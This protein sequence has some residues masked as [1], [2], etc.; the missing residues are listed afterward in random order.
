MA[1][2]VHNN[3][4]VMRSI[5]PVAIGTTGT[6][7]TGK[8]VD[9]S[10]YQGVEFIIGYGTITSTTAAFTLVVKEGDAT[11][12]MTSIADSDLLGT[13][14]AAVPA[15]G[16]RVSGSNK[17]VTKRLGY[18]GQK[19]YVQVSKLSSLGTAGPPVHADVLLTNPVSAPVAT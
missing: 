18:I 17:N 11:G 2:D 7:Q 15:A 10:G 12:S 1:R 14:A 4:K 9:R 13:E 8:I 5:S 3:I 6:G 16:T 19:R